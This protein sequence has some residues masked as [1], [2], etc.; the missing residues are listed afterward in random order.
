M[1]NVAY[2]RVSSNSQ[3][4]DRQLDSIVLDKIFT[5][6]KSGKSANDRVEL[7]NCLDYV[8]EGDTLHVHSIDRLARNLADL[9]SII[10]YANGKGVTVQFH[11]EGL[12]FLADSTNPMNKLMMQMIGAFAEFERNL[13]RER[14]R[15]GIDKALAKGTKFGAKEKLTKSQIAELKT[16]HSNGEK[17]SKLAAEYGITRQTVYYLLDPSKKPIQKK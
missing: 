6:T 15:E 12:T 16:R 5:E 2:I 3:N 8:R 7:Q 13:I 4:T 14:Q 1:A 10:E 17:I 11:K 9:Q